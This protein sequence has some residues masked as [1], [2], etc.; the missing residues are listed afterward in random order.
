MQSTRNVCITNI[1]LLL[2]ELELSLIMTGF[3]EG[4]R[5]NKN[6]PTLYPI[7]LQKYTSSYSLY[8]Q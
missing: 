4:E 1:V 6:V 7:K 5:I 3:Q 8:K 2:L